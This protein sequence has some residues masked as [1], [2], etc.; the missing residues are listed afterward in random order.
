MEMKKMRKKENGIQNRALK[1]EI[2]EGVMKIQKNKNVEDVV[3]EIDETLG[4]LWSE[5]NRA[6][7]KEQVLTVTNQISQKQIAACISEF[8]EF[9]AN[10]IA[11][12]LGGILRWTKDIETSVS[13]AECILKFKNDTNVAVRIVSDLCQIAWKFCNTPEKGAIAVKIA[14]ESVSKFEGIPEKGREAAK[15]F[16]ELA[17]FC[18]GKEDIVL[19]EFRVSAHIA[20]ITAIM[21][22]HKAP[23]KIVLRH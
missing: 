11:G 13:A 1:S 18:Y 12:N 8:T 4:L 9:D 23:Y 6:Y 3:K 14:T 22:G 17:D 10:C 15:I 16:S 5:F 7:T 21:N 2:N 20:R 19:E